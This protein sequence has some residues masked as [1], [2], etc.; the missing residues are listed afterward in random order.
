MADSGARRHGL[1]GHSLLPDTI[2]PE[3][4]LHALPVGLLVVDGNLS[5]RFWNHWLEQASDKTSASVM[6]KKLQDV[7]PR[8]DLSPLAR[9]VRQVLLLGSYAFLDAELNGALLPLPTMRQMNPEFDHRQQNV[10]LVP[11]RRDADGNGLVA[12]TIVDATAEMS[13]RRQLRRL[14]EELEQ[15]R[16]T[17]LL[18]GL[19]SRTYLNERLHIEL[20]RAAR[21]HAPLSLLMLDLDHFKR[22]NDTFGHSGGDEVLRRVG[23]TLLDELRSTDLPARFGG[24]EIVVLLPDTP[25]ETAA[26]CAERLRAA[27]AALSFPDIEGL[28]VTTSI[29]AAQWRE[30]EPSRELMARADQALYV[31]KSEGRNRVV[32]DPTDSGSLAHVAFDAAPEVS[33]T[34]APP[35]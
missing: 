4:I 9:R 6:G 22:V 10:T 1:I 7:Y 27:I 28:S 12:I 3:L 31:A 15:Q 23:R 24:E 16:R 19:A 13:A 11:Y 17:D 8:L 35:A 30:G 18:T 26:S 2:S 14:N 29:G 21:Q 5:I 34:Q 25:I 32:I 20:D 33:S